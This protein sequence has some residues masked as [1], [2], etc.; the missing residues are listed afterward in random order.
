LLVVDREQLREIRKR[1]L[2]SGLKFDHISTPTRT[3]SIYNVDDTRGR[4]PAS[5]IGTENRNRLSA[6]VSYEYVYLPTNGS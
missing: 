5:K 2:P 4:K 1:R 6:R 3:A